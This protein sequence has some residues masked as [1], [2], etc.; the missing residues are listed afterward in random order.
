MKEI[1]GI[2]RQVL[3]VDYSEVHLAMMGSLLTEA[4]L[5]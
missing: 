3:G 1:N 5:S 2:A 4:I